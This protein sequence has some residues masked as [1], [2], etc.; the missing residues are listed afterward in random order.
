MM[1]AVQINQPKTAQRVYKLEHSF[2]HFVD[3][4]KYDAELLSQFPGWNRLKNGF[5]EP[6][7]ITLS[8]TEGVLVREQRDD[9]LWH[10]TEARMPEQ[11]SFWGVNS[12]LQQTDYPYT[13]PSWPIM[14]KRMLEVLLAVEDFPHQAIPIEIEDATVT[15]VI[16][17][18]PKNWMVSGT[19]NFNYVIFQLLEHLDVF[20]WENSV[21]EESSIAPGFVSDVS[22]IVLK[23]PENGFPPIFRM[24]TE[25]TL[26]FISVE[27]RA[28]LEAAGIKGVKFSTYQLS[29]ITHNA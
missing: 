1:M 29:S 15:K 25:S 26:L 23:E 11:I 7:H 4:D 8:G 20:D 28:A 14:S 16:G 18:D 5:F 12:M 3:E 27:A 17:S 24:K 6:I 22:K 13:K 2:E 9:G 19:K 10:I 21:Y